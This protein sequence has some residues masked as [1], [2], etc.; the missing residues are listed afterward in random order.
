MR[1]HRG[2]RGSLG[3]GDAT[4]RCAPGSVPGQPPVLGGMGGRPRGSW[5]RV[6]AGGLQPQAAQPLGAPMA[7]PRPPGAGL[8]HVVAHGPT[9]P[10]RGCWSC[11]RA[12][13][14]APRGTRPPE[15][16]AR[17][18]DCTAPR[19]RPSSLALPGTLQRSPK[20]ALWGSGSLGRVGTTLILWVGSWREG[21]G[22][23]EAWAPPPLGDSARPTPGK[24]GSEPLTPWDAGRPHQ[25]LGRPSVCYPRPH[26]RLGS[27]TE[28]W[29][30]ASWT[31][32]VTPSP[33]V[34]A[35]GTQHIPSRSQSR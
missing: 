29:T 7:T 16:P 32:P 30:D 31:L 6:L 27:S 17:L 4:L 12:Q 34:P 9:A 22:T 2:W 33:R 13:P 8:S 23:P 26:P 28:H 10:R 18:A 5:G 15:P 25:V 11:S 35:A 19:H 1:R 24:P 14:G 20:A 21:P 3:R